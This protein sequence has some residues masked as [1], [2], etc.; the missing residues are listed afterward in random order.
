MLL[1]TSTN[2]SQ[3]VPALS[4]ELRRNY[5][6]E[7]GSPS[8]ASH[9][10]VYNQGLLESFGFRA[11]E[12]I[13]SSATNR[14]LKTLLNLVESGTASSICGVFYATE[15]SAIPEL[16]LICDITDLY[17]KRQDGCQKTKTLSN[18]FDLHL[19]GVEQGHKDGLGLFINQYDKYNLNLSEIRTG[20]FAAVEAMKT[21]WT[22]LEVASPT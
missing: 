22:S 9:F 21:R 7:I 6:E 3:S 18:F 13:V 1:A 16:E 5:E 8:E 2:N 14:F 19:N 20:F 15:A 4:A 12:Y 11:D 10:A 17:S